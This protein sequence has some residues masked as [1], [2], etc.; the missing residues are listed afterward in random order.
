MGTSN[1][2]NISYNIGL[3]RKL[4]PESI[5][6]VGIG[7]GRW[8]ILFREFLE[9]WDAAKYN[10]EW[11]RIIDGV[12]IFPGYIKPYHDYFY[13]TIYINDALN[14]MKSLEREYDLIN[15]GDVIE[16][17]EKEKGEE[18]INIALAKSKYVL[19]NI[20]IGPHWQQDETEINPHEAHKSIW[21]YRDFVKYKYNKIK[22]FNDFVKRDFSVILLSRNKIKYDN[23]FGKFFG[24]KNFLKHKLGL[25]KI[26]ERY[27]KSKYKS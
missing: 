3:I 20:P 9:I 27:E 8:G 1:W 13:D 22:S 2:Q 6:D 14:F 16:H 26:V 21:Y 10:G 18:L 5:L 4:N 11:E 19:I 17:L 15:F 24:I 25:R 12:E 7:F 23:R